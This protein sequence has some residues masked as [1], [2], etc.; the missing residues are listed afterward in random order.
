MVEYTFNPNAQEAEAD[1]SLQFEASLIYSE[2]QVRLHSKTLSLKPVFHW[3]EE[4]PSKLVSSYNS[5]CPVKIMLLSV[6]LDPNL[7]KA[8]KN[9]D[10]SM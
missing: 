1:G 7:F 10:E 5:E 3:E 8:S 9:V 4:Y 6:T 2:F